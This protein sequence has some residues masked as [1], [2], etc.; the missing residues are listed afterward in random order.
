MNQPLKQ[1]EPKVTASVPPQFKD[2]FDRIL[3]AGRKLIWSSP[4]YEK[5]TQPYIQAIQGPQDIAPKVSHGVVKVISLVIKEAKIPPKL[6]NPFYPASF[7]AAQVLMADA[8]QYVESSRKIPVAPDLIAAT[9]QA[10]NAG[11]VK[12]YGIKPEQV[13]AALA[14]AQKKSQ[15]GV[16]EQAEPQAAPPAAPPQGV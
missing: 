15:G 6:D 16:M 3:T 12:L 7:P 5:E 1:I 13:K 14:Q 2:E 9:T 8:L 4:L 10:I 11:L